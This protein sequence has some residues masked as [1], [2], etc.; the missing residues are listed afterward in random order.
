MRTEMISPAELR[1]FLIKK[2]EQWM[3]GAEFMAGIEKA[4][5][6]QR[7]AADAAEAIRHE[8]LLDLTPL[9]YEYP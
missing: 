1:R 4:T 7:A 3:H 6:A 2:H 5:I 9:D 8:F